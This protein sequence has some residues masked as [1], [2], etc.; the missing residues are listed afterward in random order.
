MRVLIDY[1]YELK[2]SIVYDQLIGFFR[3]VFYANLGFG[4]VVTLRLA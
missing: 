1:F 3:G 4:F 2:L